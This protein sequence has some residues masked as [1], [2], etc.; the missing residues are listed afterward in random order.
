MSSEPRIREYHPE[1]LS[2]RGELI[3]WGSAALVAA[4]WLYLLF[5]GQEVTLAVPILMVFLFLAG[6][7]ISLGNWMD[8]RTVICID[9]NGIEFHNGVR[10]V[11]LT[12]SEVEEM[13][14]LPT[15]WGKKVQVFGNRIFFEFRTLGEVKIGGDLKG[16]M[17]FEEG[18]EIMQEIIVNSDLQVI[19][20]S[21]E[22]YYYARE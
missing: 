16:R 14:V 11:Q 2:R 9:P 22:S 6:T 12:W 19:K 4:T 17:G 1:L 18:E 21:G 20:E 7:S 10:N 15:R 8:R 3:A 5:R 13:R